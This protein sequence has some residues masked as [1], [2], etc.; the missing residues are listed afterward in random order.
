MGLSSLQFV[1]QT[2]TLFFKKNYRKYRYQGFGFTYLGYNLK[3]P[4]FRDIRVRQAINYAIDKQELIDGILLGMGSICTGPFAPRSWAYNDKIKP[5]TFDPQKSLQLMA[6]AGW[7]LNKQGY[8]E[9]N[10]ELFEFTIITN[11]G[12]DERKQAAE[13]IQK[14][15]KNIGIKVKI[16]VI[17]W[18]AFINEF[19]NKRKFETVLLGWSLSYDPDIF[20]I[21]HSSK[22]K[23]GEFNFVGYRNDKV[24]ALLAQ[25]RREFNQEKRKAI[26]HNIHEIIYEEQPYLFLYNP[27]SLPIVNSRFE[28]IEVAPS[29]IS[30]NFIKWYVPKSK[31]IYISRD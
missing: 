25:G 27:D 17:E 1:R 23:E 30:H 3:N 31:Q 5:I 8:L 4:K 26:Y 29:G 15:L 16:K 6:E 14:R 9:K 7:L 21:W 11:Q 10:K 19:I 12:N 24:D 28:G 20:D 18:S 13:I 2:N 22:T